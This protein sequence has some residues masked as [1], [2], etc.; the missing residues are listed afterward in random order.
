LARFDD[1]T[2][3]L[4]ERSIGSGTLWVLAAGW[5]PEES[6]L[7][8]STKFVPLLLGMFDQTLGRPKLLQ[9]YVIGDR[10]PLPENVEVTFQSESGKPVVVPTPENILLISEF[11]LYQFSDGK[12]QWT[13]VSNLAPEE[14][15]T[16]PLTT[17]VLEQQGVNL[18]R[19]PNRETLVESERQ[20]KDTELERSQQIWKWL[21][22]GAM[23][24]LISETILG[25]R[26]ATRSVAVKE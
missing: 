14:S 17:D 15:R 10:V 2:P 6:Q 19:V 16:A 13:A 12:K 23:G 3:A 20:K 9:S 7:A 1:Q 5:Q 21:L 11:G 22:V 25:R 8:L 26:S 24:I 18:G 4:L